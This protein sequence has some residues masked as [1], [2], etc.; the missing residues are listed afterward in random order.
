[1]IVDL[2]YSKLTRPAIHGADAGRPI[3]AAA[4]VFTLAM[5]LLEKATAS[6]GA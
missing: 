3:A 5:P 2:L 4:T 6:A 1:M